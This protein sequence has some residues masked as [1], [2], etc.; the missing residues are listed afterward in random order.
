MTR[1]QAY[2]S[3]LKYYFQQ[4]VLTHCYEPREAY[5]V[6]KRYAAIYTFQATTRSLTTVSVEVW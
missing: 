2:F 4:G 1:R 5:Q 3:C 6:A